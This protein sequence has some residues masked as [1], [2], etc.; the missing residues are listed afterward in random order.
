VIETSHASTHRRVRAGTWLDM[1]TLAAPESVAS[2]CDR[3]VA[4]LVLADGRLAG[5]ATC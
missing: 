2:M 5:R 3:M 1:T 4:A